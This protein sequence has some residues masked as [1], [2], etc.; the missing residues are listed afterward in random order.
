MSR[1]LRSPGG[2][3]HSE[4]AA[5]VA[6][7]GEEKALTWFD[8]EFTASGRFHWT[9][10]LER[11]QLMGTHGQGMKASELPEFT[12]IDVVSRDGARKI[13]LA[14]YLA[15]DDEGRHPFRR[16][17]FP[18]AEGTARSPADAL[19]MPAEAEKRRA[20][21][22]EAPAEAMKAQPAAMLA[23]SEQGRAGRAP[24]LESSLPYQR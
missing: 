21:A 15:L 16:D 13:P 10:F 2:A 8:R 11:I 19:R 24:A 9:H 22:A 17:P 18:T 20:D 6:A 4:F 23:L 1:K 3:L 14:E 12:R 5:Q 7:I